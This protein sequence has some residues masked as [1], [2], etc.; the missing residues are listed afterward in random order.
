MNKRFEAYK[1]NRVIKR[2]GTD[3][4]FFRPIRNRYGEITDESTS[5]GVLRCLYH[6]DNGRIEVS[7]NGA[8]STWRD[9]QSPY[10]TATIKDIMVLDLKVEDFCTI[11]GKQHTIGGIVDIQQWGIIGTISLE[12]MDDGK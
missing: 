12:V 2:T 6:E 5:V 7:R 11:G 10:L 4:E 1:L 3:V 9:M 8:F